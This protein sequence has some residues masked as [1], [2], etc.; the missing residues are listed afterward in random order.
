[1]IRSKGRSS[2]MMKIPI[3]FPQQLTNSFFLSRALFY[4]E[5]VAIFAPWRAMELNF[6]CGHRSVHQPSGVFE[7]PDVPSDGSPIH[8]PRSRLFH[9]LRCGDVLYGICATLYVLSD[10]S[11][12]HCPRS[13]FFHNLRRGICSKEDYYSKFR[14]LNEG[15]PLTL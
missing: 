9:R 6:W 13:P 4:F 1:M 2:F 14:T 12:T 10:N 7:T 3:K 8:Q 15:A 5:F 11:P